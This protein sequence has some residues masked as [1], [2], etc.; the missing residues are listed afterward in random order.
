M[1]QVP[2]V[3]LHRLNIQGVMLRR[4][5]ISLQLSLRQVEDGDV[6]AQQPEGGRLLATAACEAEYVQAIYLAQDAFR[7]DDLAGLL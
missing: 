6:G 5:S 2:H 4:L 7:V 1:G 3:A